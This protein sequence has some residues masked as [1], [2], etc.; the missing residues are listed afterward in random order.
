LELLI[1]RI[2]GA[3]DGNGREPHA[4]PA[5]E[6]ALVRRE[7]KAHPA[8]HSAPPA[9]LSTTPNIPGLL[10]ALRRRWLLALSLG[11]LLAPPVAITVWIMRPI[12][13]AA[14]TT[15]RVMQNPPG[16]VFQRPMNSEDFANY[17]RVQIAMLKGR[18]VLNAALQNPKLKTVPIIWDQPDP[19]TWLQ[20]QIQADFAVAPEILRIS[21]VGPD[22]TALPVIVD[23]VRD[24]Y[25]KEVVDDETSGRQKRYD[26]LKRYQAEWDS[27]LQ[28]KRETLKNLAKAVGTKDGKVLATAQEL[29]NRYVQE[30]QLELFRKNSEIEAWRM[31]L[32]ICKMN[33]EA[34]DKSDVGVP[35]SPTAV[36]ELIKQDLVVKGLRDKI[37]RHDMEIAGYKERSP[38]PEKEGGYQQALRDM[39]AAKKALKERTAEIRPDIVKQVQERA[40]V[41]QH[42]QILTL[43]A[44]IKYQEQWTDQLKKHF[45]RRKQALQEKADKGV[46][47]EWL[48]DDIAQLDSL[49]K[50]VSRQRQV[51]EVELDAPPRTK[52]HEEAFVVPAQ[53]ASSRLR[54]AGGAGLGTFAAVLFGIAF[55]EFRR[56]RVTSADEVVQGLKMKLVGSLPL[57]PRRALLGRSSG[58]ENAEWQSRLTESVD[59]IRTTLLSAA[60]FEGLRRVMVTSAIGGEGKTLLACHLAVSLARAGCKTLLIDGDL[61]RPS[62]HRLFDMPLGHGL[63]ELLRRELQPADVT[64]PGPILNLSVITAGR[65]DSQAI[66]GLARQRIA[67]ILEQVSANYEFIVVDS[68]PVLPVADSQLIGQHVDGVV[69]SVMRDVSRLPAVYAACERL[70]LLRI[71]VLG[72]VVN[73]MEGNAY[74]TAYYYSSRESAETAVPTEASSSPE[75]PAPAEK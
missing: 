48:H 31:Q 21:M 24:A 57:V 46:D 16:N 45:E 12:T 52:L 60:R 11:L 69:F 36:D 28:D 29:E 4:K 32:A 8:A 40:R 73:G 9:A 44:K 67:E 47:L 66:Q 42:Q 71:R 13:F 70:S 26:Q 30:L 38:A 59:A 18:Y 22:P 62:V 10:L 2:P 14:F 7:V 43:D 33:E 17:Q 20:G 3:D 68:A 1:M 56:R 64:H 74:R 5:T 15:L 41:E 39:E 35:V 72:A 19:L 37:A 23:A 75:A 63:S 65:S 34:A 61:R 58:A 27:R 49:I 6:H 51:L 25:L 54:M 53:T 55:L 50:E